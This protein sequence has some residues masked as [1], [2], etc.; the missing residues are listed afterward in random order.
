MTDERYTNCEAII[1]KCR[2][3][4]E[5]NRQFHFISPLYGIQMATAFGAEKLKSRFCP[6]V[7]NFVSAKLFLNRNPKSGLLKLDD[8]SE[9]DTNDFVKSS[10]ENIYMLSFFSDVLLN[11]YMS[12]EEYRNFYFLLKYSMDLLAEKKD[13]MRSFLFFTSKYIF[14]SGYGLSLK[15]CKKCGNKG[16]GYFFDFGTHGIFCEK[17]AVDRRYGLSPD[18]VAVLERY[19]ENKFKE[20]KDEAIDNGSF[21]EIFS[22]TVEILKNI[23]SRELKTFNL[24]DK[25]FHGGV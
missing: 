20:L 23:F 11:T 14:L 5:I 7:Q 1:L 4:G 10:L 17:C 24:L 12:N 3:S 21:G 22:I 25:I 19:F 9:I 2:A 18:S 15:K 13:L 6:S 16:T 8:I